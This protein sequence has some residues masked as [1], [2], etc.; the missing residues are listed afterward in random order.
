MGTIRTFADLVCA[1]EARTVAHQARPRARLVELPSPADL[2]GPVTI[3]FAPRARFVTVRQGLFDHLAV[4]RL[5]ELEAAVAR[6]NHHVDAPGFALDHLRRRLYARMALPLFDGIDADHLGHVT[7]AVVASASEF[8]PSFGAVIAGRPGR[9]I[10][11]IYK[12]F[13]HARRAAVA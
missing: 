4:D 8:Q 9:D 1:L 11:Q 12:Q 3:A 2:P 10:A 7:R 6:I 5:P 13:S